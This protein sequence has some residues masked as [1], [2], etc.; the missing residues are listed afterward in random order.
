MAVFKHHSPSKPVTSI[1]TPCGKMHNGT[2]RLGEMEV[3]SMLMQCITV[4]VSDAVE[5]TD[6]SRIIICSGCSTLLFSCDC[7]VLKPASR[8]V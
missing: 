1:K 2:P 8:L 6:G 5:S 3:L 7:E 4:N